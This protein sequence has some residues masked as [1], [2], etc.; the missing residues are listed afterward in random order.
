MG[1]ERMSLPRVTLV[2]GFPAS[3]K[4]TLT[5]SLMAKGFA[6]LNRDSEGGTMRNLLQ[7]FRES[8]VADAKVVLDNTFG[9]VVER[10]PF[11]EAA[12]AVDVKIDCC[13]MAT[14]AEDAQVNAL[15]RMW[16]RYGQVFLD[17]DEIKAHEAARKD[18]N[19]F[20]PAA[21]FA[22]KKRFEKPTVEE[23]FARVEKVPFVRRPPKG[24]RKALILDYDGTLRRDA[25]ECGGQFHYPVT[26]NQVQVLPNRSVVLQRY[27]DQGYLLL[28]ASTQSGIAKGHLSSDDALACF[29]ETN[30]QLGLSI[31][32][33]HCKH[34]SFPVACYCRKPQSGL[35]VYL[36]RLYDLDPAQCVM[37]GDLGTDRTFADRCGF[38]F[39]TADD[40]FK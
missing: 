39:A 3:G 10:E 31:T 13:W 28:G 27:K 32:H 36:T 24:T 15:H 14:S 23:G 12:R 26:P 33:A 19:I 29:R 20:P 25:M 37:V 4:S 30:R 21:I 38:Q 22:Y 7:K 11:I 5:A 18:P 9:T 2:M 35:G 40:F 17:A 8:L 16:D 6:I 34:G 1:K